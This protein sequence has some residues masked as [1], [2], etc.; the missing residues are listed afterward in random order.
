MIYDKKT[1]GEVRIYVD[2][3]KLDDACL[4]D[5]FSKP[6][7]DEVLESIEG[8]EIYSFTDGFYGYHQVR[9]TKEDRQKMTFVIEWGCYQYIVIPFGIKNS[10]VIFSRIVVTAFKYF[11]HKFLEVYFDD[12]IVFGLV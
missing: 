8:Q 7:T 1:M 10:P 6:F 2:L 11:I 3:R 9:I 12:W 5:P 4:H